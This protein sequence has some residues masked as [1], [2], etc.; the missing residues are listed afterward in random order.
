MKQTKTFDDQRLNDLLF[1]VTEREL[2]IPDGIKRVIPVLIHGDFTISVPY[3]QRR[4][5]AVALAN[6]L[7]GFGLRAAFYEWESMTDDVARKLV[8][9]Y[10][11]N[12]I[13]SLVGYTL[14]KSNHSVCGESL[15]FSRGIRRNAF[16]VS[17]Y[18]VRA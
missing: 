7:V 9:Y 13:A 1:Q 10:L 5:N 15:P 6:P 3:N 16:E 11:E 14:T 4:D 18:Y 2:T 12:R 17:G 8:G